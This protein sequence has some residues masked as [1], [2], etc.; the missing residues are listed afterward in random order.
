V[1][2]AIE[3]WQWLLSEE[4][5]RLL[6]AG[7]DVDPSDVS[8]IARL[9]KHWSLAQV[10]AAMELIDAR[11]R[12][13]LKYPNHPPVVCDRPGIEQATPE[14]IAEYKT[15]RLLERTGPGSHVQDLACGIGGDAMSFA[16]HF[17]V[18]ALDIDPLRCWMTGHNAGCAT[19]QADILDAAPTGDWFHLD[20][21]R[22]DP[23]TGRRLHEPNQW[24]PPISCLPS[25][26]SVFKGGIVKLGPGVLIDQLPTDAGHGL[27]FLSLNGR[28]SQAHLWLG[29]LAFERGPHRATML[30][31]GRTETGTPIPPPL[32]PIGS[33]GSVLCVPDPALERSMLHGNLAEQHQLLEPAP[34]LGL[35]T[36]DRIP[37]STWFTSFEVDAVMPWREDRVVRWLREHDTGLV[38]IKTRDRTVDPD[39]HQRRLSGR[40]S[41]ARTVF[42]LRMGRPVVAVI[43]RRAANRP[44]PDDQ[45]STGAAGFPDD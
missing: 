33:I 34:G 41:I 23:A 22:R 7:S 26:A 27:E 10:S 31:S 28:L 16:R 39:R 24:H 21:G 2:H 44:S 6:A 43:T 12:A 37:D 5:N 3:T 18:T 1:S 11:R 25:L 20:P 29:E 9:R 40:G 35:L 36:G 4:G 13:S 30:P 8:A 32:G 15:N 38:E 14:I 45:S 42:V 17:E 19:V